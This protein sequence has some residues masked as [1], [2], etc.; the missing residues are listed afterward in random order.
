[1]SRT[2]YASVRHYCESSA[3]ER[4]LIGVALLW[5]ADERGGRRCSLYEEEGVVEVLEAG[6]E[7]DP[8]G[9]LRPLEEEDA[10]DDEPLAS[11]I[12][13]DSLQIFLKDIGK[14]DL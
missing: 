10:A 5:R 13:T 1:M 4:G 8:L 11:E 2:A 9:A 7:L 3:S 12:S 14:V 6:Q